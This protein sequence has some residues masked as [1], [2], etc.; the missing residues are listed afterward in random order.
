MKKF[1]LSTI[2][3]LLCLEFSSCTDQ[4][5]ICD[6]IKYANLN[7]SFYKITAGGESV[8]IAPSFSLAALNGTLIY[9]QQPNVSNFGLQLVPAIDSASY[10]IS[11]S[12]SLPADTFNIYYSSSIQNLSVE[13]GNIDV[14][15]IRLIRTTNH[16]ID[17]IVI[18]NPS[19]RNEN[20]KNLKFYF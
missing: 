17:S 14:H 9:N 1:F 7:A 6:Q 5:S 8:N 16:T 15:D 2:T 20:M 18:A 4:Y 3:F 19:V 12:A 10:I 11:F 13:C